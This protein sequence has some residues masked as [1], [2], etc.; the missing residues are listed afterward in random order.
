L[1]VGQ[2]IHSVMAIRTMAAAPRITTSTVVH[3]L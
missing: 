3:E 2:T 1:D